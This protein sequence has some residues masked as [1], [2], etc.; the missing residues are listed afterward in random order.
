MQLLFI[1][2]GH[3][4]Q[5]WLLMCGVCVKKFKLKNKWKKIKF[6]FFCM[7]KKY[8]KKLIKILIPCG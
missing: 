7:K 5:A 2:L 8:R 4:I 3:L 6:S 1:I